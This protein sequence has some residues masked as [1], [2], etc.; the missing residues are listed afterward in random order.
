MILDMVRVSKKTDP[1]LVKKG[2]MNLDSLKV[3]IVD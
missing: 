1:D 2:K 3:C